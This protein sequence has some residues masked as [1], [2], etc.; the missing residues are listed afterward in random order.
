MGMI[1]GKLLET[2][3]YFFMAG[4]SSSLES[5]KHDGGERSEGDE[6]DEGVRAKSI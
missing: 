1:F 3:Q 2:L 4:G 6:G 5:L